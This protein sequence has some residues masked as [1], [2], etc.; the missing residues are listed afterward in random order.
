MILTGMRR[1]EA[2]GLRWD[3]V[4]GAITISGSR[5]KNH[6]P[7]V[8]PLSMQA[9]ALIGFRAGE[10]EYVFSYDGK[11][12]IGDLSTYVAKLA[13]T[14]PIPSW[15]LHDL[16]RSFAS[17]CQGL[18]VQPAIID[19]CLGH[20]SVIRG[21]ARVYLR[22]RYLDERREAMRVWGAHIEKITSR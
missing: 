13:K 9:S 5:T 10:C 14:M 19:A 21:T 12:A 11:R 8:V 3:E 16:R 4:G 18:G 15:R 20:S 17:G 22:G 2:G 1:N 7:H 6:M